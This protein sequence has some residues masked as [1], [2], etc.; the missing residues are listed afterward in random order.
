[1]ARVNQGIHWYL[2]LLHWGLIVAAL[3][4]R[5]VR[6]QPLYGLQGHVGLRT[7]L[8]LEKRKKSSTGCGYFWSS[9]ERKNLSKTKPILFTLFTTNSIGIYLKCINSNHLDEHLEVLEQ[10]ILQVLDLPVES[11]KNLIF[12]IM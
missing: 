1:M 3:S 5:N 10:G 4:P 8:F 6:N 9:L 11:K 2:H 12:S 7:Y